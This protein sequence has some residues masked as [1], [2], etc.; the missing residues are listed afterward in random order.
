MLCHRSNQFE[1]PSL[2]WPKYVVSLS[3]C[4]VFLCTMT[5]GAALGFFSWKRWGFLLLKHLL[6][7]HYLLFTCTD[8]YYYHCLLF[9]VGKLWWSHMILHTI[10]WHIVWKCNQPLI[11]GLAAQSRALSF[12]ISPDCS[13]CGC[14]WKDKPLRTKVSAKWKYCYLSN[15]SANGI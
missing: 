7:K 11:I 8:F 9:S 12:H 4:D 2:P 1:S 5:K 10:R 6:A 13:F 15:H 14:M 3:E